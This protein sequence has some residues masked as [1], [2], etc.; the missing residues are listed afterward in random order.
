MFKNIKKSSALLFII[1][2][3]VA[4]SCIRDEENDNLS[5]PSSRSYEEL[6]IGDWDCVHTF[7][8]YYHEM[9]GNVWQDTTRID[10]WTFFGDRWK[11]TSDGKWYC[12]AIEYGTFVI[13][14]D[15]FAL[16]HP[17]GDITTRYNY[18]IKASTIISDGRWPS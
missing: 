3:M 4:T 17:H 8:H 9:G 1:I 11:F 15:M 7:D 12:N 5:T 16:T 13:S 2:S 18:K 14:G 10:G 6:I